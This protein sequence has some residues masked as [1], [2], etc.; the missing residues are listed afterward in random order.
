MLPLIALTIVC[1][2]TYTFEIVFGLAGTVLML[3]ALTWMY[4]AKTLVIY[5]AMPQI[6]VATIGL[7]RSPGHV[8]LSVLAGMLAF[9]GLG[10]LAGLYCFYQFPLRLFQF[11]L[12]TGIT[13]FGIY[14]VA[15][16]NR[17]RLT[18]SRARS[19]DT[20]AGFSA[21]LF[22]ISGPIVMT[23]LMATFHDKT[24]IRN[25]ALA[26]FLS[27][28]LI[29]VGGYVLNGTFTPAIL[30]MMLISGP[31]IAVTLWYSNQLHFHV[32]EAIFRRVVSWVILLG[33]LSLFFR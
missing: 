23:R 7:L 30:K 20:L 16:P 12:A 2:V 13:V 1:I 32:N 33:G 4:D 22:G 19:L 10:A 25:N 21:T 17:L 31:V 29:R 24:T 11:L 27:L 18:P 15:T 3:T 8:R 26:F 14:L 6:L 9:A 5:S 28:N